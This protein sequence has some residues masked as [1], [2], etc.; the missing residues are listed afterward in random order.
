MRVLHVLHE[1]RPSGAE[2]MVH[3]IAPMWKQHGWEPHILAIGPELGPFAPQLKADGYQVHHIR[4]ARRTPSFY[5][6][7]RQLLKQQR[8]E[9]VHIHVQWPSAALAVWARLS[10][11]PRIVQTVHAYFNFRGL[12][13]LRSIMERWTARAVGC[14]HM[15]ISDA[16]Y[17]N[18]LACLWNRSAIVYN[19]YD[20]ARFTPAS[21]ERRTKARRVFGLNNDEIAIVTVGNCAT[22][23]NH[24]SL[25][26]A[27]NQLAGEYRFV[28]LHAGV[29]AADQAERAMAAP[30]QNGRARFLGQVD[31]VPMLLHA[32]DLYVQP[33]LSEGFGIAALEAL[34]C[35]V[36]TLLSDIPSFREFAGIHPHVFFAEPT[37]AGLTA[38]LRQILSTVQ[39]GTISRPATFLPERLQAFLPLTGFSHWLRVYS[40]DAVAWRADCLKSD[41]ATR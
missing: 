32:A 28:Y 37:A 31:D 5:L 41:I 36:P 18:E 1:L 16:V 9:V 12:V 8:Y 19:W 33:S 7:F 25:I 34:A 24:P 39:G 11:V 14:R 17:R 26:A 29:E 10:G 15:S 6:A 30:L 23:K 20:S 40:E 21:P 22:V 2:V 38:M 4:Y 35:G 27:M 13:R 3:V